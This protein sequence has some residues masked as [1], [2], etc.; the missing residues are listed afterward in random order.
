MVDIERPRGQ[1]A[2]F[3]A[4]DGIRA[5]AALLVIL[6]H[7]PQA[8]DSRFYNAIWQI[9]QQA[10]MAYVALDVFFVVSGFFITRLLLRERFETGSISFANFYMRRALRIF[11]VYYLA[12]VACIVIFRFGTADAI[13][14]LTY[15]YNF[16]HPFHA[17]P[18]PL[19]HT[20]SLSVEEQFYLFWPL[21]ILLVPP[22]WLNAVMGCIVPLLAISSGLLLA[23]I[24]LNDD[25]R[26]AGDVVYMSLFTRMLSLSLGGW[27]ALREF[28]N[29]PLRGWRCLALLVGGLFVIT[30]DRV[31]RNHGIISSQPVYWTIAL[32]GYVM[33][34]VSFIATMIFDRG[35]LQRMMATFLSISLMRKLG[36][37]SYAMYVFHLPVLFYFG[38]NDAALN[39][40]KVPVLQV[41]LAL[42]ITLVLPFL[43]YHLLETP[44]AKLKEGLGSTVLKSK[45]Q[46]A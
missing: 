3:P 11:P 41:Y 8:S 26:V 25:A 45:P 6:S 32:I 40:A 18:N 23:I 14:L 22:R 46:Q 9:N 34:S 44:M 37:M 4:F 38:L 16:Y 39:G 29:K 19:E 2:R 17:T 5:V 1:L 33:I 13:S 10:R 43:S 7:F 12:V 21:A 27:L 30:L 20:W 36:Q 35:L 31:G 42:A 15:T 24:L 28:E